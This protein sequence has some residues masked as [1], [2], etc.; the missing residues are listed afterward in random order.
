MATNRPPRAAQP[1]TP[2]GPDL[3]AAQA[4]ATPD[5]AAVVADGAVMRYRDL[6]RRA[7]QLA[8]QVL[9]R[10]PFRVRVQG[11]RPA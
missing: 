2:L 11:T 1:R 9:V 4:A 5:A 7:N 6:D 10:L 8:H 3:V